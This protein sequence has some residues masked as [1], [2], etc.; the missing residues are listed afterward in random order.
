MAFDLGFGRP[1]ARGLCVIGGG[2]RNPAG[3]NPHAGIDIRLPEGTP[4]FAVA[5]GVVTRASASPAGDLGIFC[6]IQHASGALT[7]YLHFSQLL[8]SPGQRVAKGQQLGR[9]GNTGN[10]AGP[11]LH[12]D[13]K[14]PPGQ[15]GAGSVLAKIRAA[16]GPPATGFEPDKTGF[17]IGVPSEPWVPADGYDDVVVANARQNGIPLYDQIGHGLPLVAKLAIVAGFG[18]AAYK[19]WT[20]D[21]GGGGSG[22]PV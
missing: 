8:V 9:S 1:V 6:A 13:I 22:E 2:W 12:F 16:A 19:L 5:A 11:H 20:S 3:G 14:I 17:G 4:V 18:F 21:V 10:S 15:Q 7:R